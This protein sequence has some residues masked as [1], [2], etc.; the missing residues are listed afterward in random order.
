MLTTRLSFDPI[1][2]AGELWEE[3]FGPSTAMR[4]ATSVMRVQ[5]LMISALDTVLRSF[6]LT[7][8]RYEVLV[9]LRFSQGGALP[10]NK[11]GERLMVHPASVTNAIDRLESRGLVTR[12]ADEADRRRV[13]ASITQEGREVVQ[14]A[15]AA[16]T[17]I[18][19]AVVGLTHEQQEQTYQLLRRFRTAAGD[20]PDS[21]ER[22]DQQGGALDG[23]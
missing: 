19:F 8:A 2:R 9:L 14:A 4:L 22:D 6:E 16:I 12:L 1:D 17:E 7:F 11:I 3:N 10:L 21:V 15:T 20:F 23:Q 18:D 5:Q 13:L